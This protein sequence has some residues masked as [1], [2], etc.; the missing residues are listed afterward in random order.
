MKTWEIPLAVT[1]R[2]QA[3]NRRQAIETVKREYEGI[4][5]LI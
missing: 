5:C 4:I 3:E 2:I 1:M